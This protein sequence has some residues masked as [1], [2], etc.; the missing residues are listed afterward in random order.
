MALAAHVPPVAALCAEITRAG[1]AFVHSAATIALL[2]GHDSA[3]LR[4]W[5]A[6]ASSWN[7]MPLDTYM[8]DGGRYRRRRYATLSVA[9]GSNAATLEPHQPH[10]QSLDYNA[11][12]G[13]IARHYEP[14]RAGIVAGATLSSLLV[15]CCRVFNQLRPATHWHVEVHQFRIEARAGESGQPT[16]EGVHRDGVDY[17]MVMMIERHN[18]RE[19]T[20][21]IHGPDGARLAGFTLT[22]PLDMTLVD[23][24][25]CLHG[26]TPVVPLDAAQPAWRD[27]LVVTFRQRVR[28]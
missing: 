11:L 12:N 1:F 27:V 7:D 9:A 17:V 15:L 24:H 22:E 18:I 10:Y 23:D 26:V 3:A 8:A 6:F 19:G 28:G 20:T 5:P 21:T 14:I 13:G 4:D 25:R 16:P 2:T